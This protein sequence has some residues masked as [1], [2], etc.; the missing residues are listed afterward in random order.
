MTVILVIIA[1]ITLA[2]YSPEVALFWAVL[3]T[4]SMISE[5]ITELKDKK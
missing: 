1:L 3:A 5:A 2:E 4:G